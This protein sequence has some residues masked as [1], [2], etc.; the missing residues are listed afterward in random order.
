MSKPMSFEGNYLEGNFP[1][2]KFQARKF[3][4]FSRDISRIYKRESSIFSP[5][6]KKDIKPIVHKLF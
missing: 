1:Q 2:E 4:E 5:T 6:P 3:L